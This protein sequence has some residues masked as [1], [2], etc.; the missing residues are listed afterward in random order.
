MFKI[1]LALHIVVAI[2]VIGPLAHAAKTAGRGVRKG[3]KALV[4]D[5]AR[6]IRVYSIISVLVVLLGFGL[7]SVKVHGQTVADFGDTWIWLSLV[8]WLAAIGLV[9]AVLLP[10][11]SRITASIEREESVVGQ[12]LRVAT[13]GG[14]IGTLFVVIVFLMV[15]RPGG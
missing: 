11:L 13:V 1:L 2:F 12:T 5:A 7:M 6:V 8:L 3:D 9:H 10:Q 4:A 14:L 15:Y